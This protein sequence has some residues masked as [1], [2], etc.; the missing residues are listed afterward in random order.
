MQTEKTDAWL[1]TLNQRAQRK[2]HCVL[3]EDSLFIVIQPVYNISPILIHL[4]EKAMWEEGFKCPNQIL[5]QTLVNE[6]REK[7]QTH[8]LTL[9]CLSASVS[10]PDSCLPRCLS[11]VL[12]PTPPCG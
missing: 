12:K 2:K 3:A 1:N 6:S 9:R 10:A 5:E 7:V 8:V 4:G 11:S